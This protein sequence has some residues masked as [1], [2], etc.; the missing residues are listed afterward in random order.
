[1]PHIP[2]T[3]TNCVECHLQILISTLKPLC[4][5]FPA[6]KKLHLHVKEEKAK[7]SSAERFNILCVSSWWLNNSCLT[8]MVSPSWG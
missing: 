1:M 2:L 5:F 8:D 6:S 7:I 4:L 3:D